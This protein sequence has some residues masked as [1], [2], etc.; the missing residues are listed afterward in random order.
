MVAVKPSEVDAFVARPDPSRP[1]ILVFGA[2]AGLVRERAQALVRSGV[3]DPSD[4]FQLA[5][6]EGDDLEP[7]R[8][9]EE[10]NTIPLFGGRRAVWVR[11]GS[12]NIAPAV[13]ALTGCASPSCRVVIE[14]GDLRRNAPLRVICERAR[15]AA[16]LPCNRDSDRDIQR[17]IDDEMR[18]S[19]LSI[20]PDARA[21]LATLLGGDRLASRQE[22][23]KLA[24]FAAGKAPSQKEGSNAQAANRPRVELADIIAVVSD[25]SALALDELVDAA[26]AA[27]PAELEAEL[28]KARTAAINPD[29][30]MSAAL[31]QVAQLHKARLAVEEGT[32][33]DDAVA[34]MTPFVQFSRRSRVEGAV[35]L[36][37][38]ERL[39]RAMIQLADAALDVRRCA[40]LADAI[41]ERALLA[42]AVNARR[43]K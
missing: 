10:A 41:A 25:A 20:A 27:R 26:F 37:T 11:A 18:A 32:P 13:E 29:A 33:A 1:I 35:R 22:L 36:W 28:R 9:V 7:M 19:G 34:A 4:P 30:I 31:R 6:I 23:R 43:N 39:A 24:L 2:D 15:N 17:L 8:L 16:A 40:A 42:L 38:S 14:A 3:D 12:R 5:R 21:A